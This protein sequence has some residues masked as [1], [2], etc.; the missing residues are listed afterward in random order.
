MTG[1][2]C[3][4]LSA[5]QVML[6]FAMRSVGDFHCNGAFLLSLLRCGW[7]YAHLLLFGGAS[8]LWW[9]II[10]KYPL[11]VAYPLASFSYVFGMIAAIVFFG[12]QVSASRWA[13]ALLIV[14]GCCLIVK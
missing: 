1:L 4:L 13:G 5:G 10:K 7:F 3:L 6:K 2:Q 9:F 12:E 11:S 14:A 8:V